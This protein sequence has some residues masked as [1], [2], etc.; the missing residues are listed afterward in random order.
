M[1]T[2]K[3]YT[4]LNHYTLFC[5]HLIL[6]KKYFNLPLIAKIFVANLL[7]SKASGYQFKAPILQGSKLSLQ[8]WVNWSRFPKLVEMFMGNIATLQ[9]GLCSYEPFCIIIVISFSLFSLKSLAATWW[10]S[11]FLKD[12]L[13]KTSH[14]FLPS[15]PQNERRYH[16]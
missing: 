16:Y 9:Q 11:A 14:V 7:S 1:E 15:S 6:K 12:I 8:I 3:S 4:Y 5:K 13:L 10:K 2:G